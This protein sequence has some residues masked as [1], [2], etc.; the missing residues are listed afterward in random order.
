MAGARVSGAIA[1]VDVCGPDEAALHRF[2]DG[3]LGWRIDAKGPGYA[4]VATPGNGPDGA[5][6]ESEAASLTIGVVI[7]DL[8]AALAAV[9]GHGGRVV[10]PATDNGWVT[11]AQVAD[12]AGNLLTLIEGHR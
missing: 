9:A 1:H 12:P 7:D 10:M 4:L 11:K 2:Y 5:I 8:D 3:V 6:V